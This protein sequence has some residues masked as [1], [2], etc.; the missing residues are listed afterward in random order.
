MTRIFAFGSLDLTDKF[1]IES[2]DKVKENLR[3]YIYVNPKNNHYLLNLSISNKKEI[4]QYGYTH[5]LMASKKGTKERVYLVDLKEYD[6]GNNTAPA[7][8]QPAFQ[9]PAPQQPAVGA[10][11][12]PI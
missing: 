7:Y 1:G 4:S 10:D 11:D 12:H 2:M 3:P 6:Q 5:D 8:Q 9:Q